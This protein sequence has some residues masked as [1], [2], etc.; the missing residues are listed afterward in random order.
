MRS[1][2]PGRSSPAARSC[3]D[4]DLIRLLVEAT[5]EHQIEIARRPQPGRRV[6]EAIMRQP[7]EP[8][9]LTALA[10]NDTAEVADETCAS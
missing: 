10:S 2:S 8:A 3:K 5:L 7:R 9:V 6:V 1:R 4:H